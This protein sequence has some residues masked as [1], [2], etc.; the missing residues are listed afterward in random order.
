MLCC[1]RNSS[2]KTSYDLVQDDHFAKTNIGLTENNV[3]VERKDELSTGVAYIA[4][5]VDTGVAYTATEVDTGVAETVPVREY[6]DQEQI[7]LEIEDEMSAEQLGSAINRLESVAARLE[8]IAVSGGGS[9]K[10]AAG[11]P[12]KYRI[13]IYEKVL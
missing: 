4:T 3:S 8:Q 7:D 1:C 10:P 2:R 11:K 12:G 6:L 5:E 13:S 9:A